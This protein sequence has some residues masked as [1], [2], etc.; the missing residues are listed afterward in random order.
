M[1]LTVDADLGREKLRAAWEVAQNP[2]EEGWTEWLSLHRAWAK[3]VGGTTGVKTYPA[4]LATALIAKAAERNVNPLSLDES[5]DDP[6]SYGARSLSK[7]TIGDLRRLGLN[8]LVGGSD[9]LANHPFFKKKSYE[10]IADERGSAPARYRRSQAAFDKQVEVLK[11]VGSLTDE[12]SALMALASFLVA[13][14]EEFGDPDPGEG[15]QTAW[16][17]QCNPKLFDVDGYLG[18]GQ[19]RITWSARQKAENMA[20]G[21][22]VYLWRGVGGERDKAGIVATALVDSLPW[23]GADHEEAKPFWK[24]EAEAGQEERRVWLRVQA[25]AGKKGIVKRDWLKEDPVCSDLRILKM[26]Q[27]TNYPL[28]SAHAQRI[29]RLWDRTGADWNRAESVAAM[30]VHHCLFGKSVSKKPDSLVGKLSI[31]TGR[32]VSS[33]YSKVSNFISMDPRDERAGR[34]SASEGDKAVWAEFFDADGGGGVRAGD[35]EKEGLRLWGEDWNLSDPELLPVSAI[36]YERPDWPLNLILYGPPGTGKT[37]RLQTEY[38]RAFTQHAANAKDPLREELGKQPWYKVVALALHELG[39]AATVAEL[40]EHPYVEAK[41][42]AQGRGRTN[43][44]Q[45]IWSQLSSHTVAESETVKYSNRA[46]SKENLLFDKETDESGGSTWKFVVDLPEE[47]SEISERVARTRSAPAKV[48]QNYTFLTFHQSYSYEQFVEGIQPALLA[49]GEEAEGDLQ[50]CL[51]DGVFKQAA[52]K[53]IELA[54]FRGSLHEFCGLTREERKRALQHAPC[55][56]LLIDEVSRANVSRVFG[57]LITLIEE[58]KRLGA[59]NEVV[60]KLPYSNERFGVPSNLFIIGTMNTADRS[61]EAL[62]SALRRRFAFREV[63]PSPEV[64]DHVKVGGEVDLTDLLKTINARIVR[65][66]SRDQQIGHS[67]LLRVRDHPTLENLREVFDRQILPLLQEYFFGDW[68][69]IGLVLGA[70]FVKDQSNQVPF[71]KFDHDLLEDFEDRPLYGV[72]PVATLNL[73]AFKAIYT[74]G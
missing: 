49:E 36:P 62:D 31:L 68:G 38:M 74:D 39:G 8:L 3:T 63:P 52:T 14:R 46:S 19:G 29:S 64:L 6:G 30:W 41:R 47:L 59:E 57:E 53:A 66:A 24:D 69:K 34:T 11:K 13:V 48:Q 22:L 43:L 42:Q 28:S 61:V 5:E 60:L 73:K 72:V 33:A 65:L 45:T 27:E 44:T 54:G 25:T 40:R 17:F 1:G 15:E 10:E 70:H 9:P 55:Y 50:Y 58:D 23:N 26:A 21:D 18:S 37:F 32:A 20:L 67:Y 71:A 35:L 7:A 56:A 4:A 51:S 2:P 16:I 12:S